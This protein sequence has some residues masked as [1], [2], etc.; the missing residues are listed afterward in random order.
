[1]VDYVSWFLDADAIDRDDPVRLP[2]DVE[3]ERQAAAEAGGLELADA[4]WDA[5]VATATD[6]GLDPQAT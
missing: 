4:T 5:L 3:R 1:M 6:L 2:G